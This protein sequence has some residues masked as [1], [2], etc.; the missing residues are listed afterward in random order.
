MSRSHQFFRVRSW[1]VLETARKRVADARED[2][3]L[4][5]DG[6][7]A[8]FQTTLPDSRS[9]TFHSI[10]KIAP[11]L[12]ITCN[13]PLKPL[14]VPGRVGI[15]PA[16]AA[17]GTEAAAYGTSGGRQIGRAREAGRRASRAS[18]P[19]ES[20]RGE[21]IQ[22]TGNAYLAGQDTSALRIKKQEPEFG[23]NETG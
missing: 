14:R 11:R 3:A 17:E 22:T 23:R 18:R 15:L 4:G 6:S 7:A 8:V 19:A 12:L 2:A 5:G 21:R 20:S 1:L 16:E 9:F 13:I 10:E